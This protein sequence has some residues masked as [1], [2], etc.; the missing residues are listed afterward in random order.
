MDEAI[1]L[2]EADC[3]LLDSLMERRTLPVC[4]PLSRNGP[5]PA[6]KLT[7]SG[8]PV[9]D[10][11]ERTLPQVI[12]GPQERQRLHAFADRS[13]SSGTCTAPTTASIPTRRLD[14]LARRPS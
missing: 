8:D 3:R 10:F 12:A 5:C 4:C 9:T 6:C 1:H 14:V 13:R 2:D 11:D 7:T